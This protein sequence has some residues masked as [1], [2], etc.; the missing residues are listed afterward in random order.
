MTMHSL[1]TSRSFVP[2]AGPVFLTLEEVVERYRGQ[3]SEGTLRNWRSMRVGP[4]FI[5][6][7]KAILYP[8]E[9][10]DRWDRRNLVVCRPSRSLPLE[11]AIS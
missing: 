3:V 6:I 4:S 8:L 5:K 9:E 7:G 2:P 10:L 1:V 11:D